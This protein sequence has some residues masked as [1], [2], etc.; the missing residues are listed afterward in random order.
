MGP[1]LA[2]GKGR[3]RMARNRPERPRKQN[4]DLLRGRGFTPLRGADMIPYGDRR[5][6][7]GKADL[8]LRQSPIF[9]AHLVGETTRRQGLNLDRGSGILGAQH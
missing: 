6:M 9:S 2:L 5:L 3:D 1:P 4:P 7:Y 8:Y